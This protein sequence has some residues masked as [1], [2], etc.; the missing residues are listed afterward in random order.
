M[1]NTIS[2]KN[3]YSD[4]KSKM[5]IQDLIINF[6]NI[7]KDK[8]LEFVR[9]NTFIN[10]NID[11]NFTKNIQK[12]DFT[13]K[14]IVSLCAE[15]YDFLSKFSTEYINTDLSSNEDKKYIKPEFNKND[16]IATNDITEFNFDPI[17]IDSVVNHFIVNI[18]YPFNDKDITLNEFNSTFTEIIQKKDMI[19]I[20]KKCI[21][22]LPDY[23]KIRFINSFNSYFSDMSDNSI[24]SIKMTSFGKATYIYK[25]SKN[26]PVNDINSF[27]KIIAIPNIVSHF[28]KILSNRILSYL[29]LNN[30]LDFNIQKGCIPG[31]SNPLTQQ[32]MKV[33]TSINDAKSNNKPIAILFVDISDA[34][35]SIDRKALEFILNYYKIG[36]NCINY[37][38]NYYNNFSYY[39][40]NKNY[41]VGLVNWNSRGIIQ[42]CPLSPILF[43][44]VINFFLN[45]LNDKYLDKC[46][47]NIA[48]TYKFLFSA[49][50]DDI[51]IVV[52]NKDYL[53][54]IYTELSQLLASVGLFINKNKSGIMLSG[55]S[56]EDIQNYKLEDIPIITD[57][58]YLGANINISDSRKPVDEFI[59]QLYDRL[60]F[61]DNNN[62]DDNMKV[63]IFH[64][65]I[66]PWITR[67][68]ANLYDL[69]NDDKVNVMNV[70]SHFQR[71]WQ[72]NQVPD[73][74]INVNDV[75]NNSDDNVLSKLTFEQLYIDVSPSTITCN[76][77][78]KIKE[79]Y[80][81]TKIIIKK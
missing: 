69:T 15:I 41:D 23:H 39:I 19:G 5:T 40:K 72:D 26:G 56:I 4:I 81:S 59:T 18:K 3:E 20:S 75:L 32:I 49:Y 10:Y 63:K 57:Y 48:N 62:E 2:T 80:N 58:T 66:L 34:F 77:A 27:R 60:T 52:N 45:Y 29:K 51:C 28:H 22:Y 50:V 14:N 31:I 64:K 37:I 71:K 67:Q 12:Y 25:E 61:L 13:S 17:N 74:F 54:D 38:M 79:N 65:N 35:G 68:T 73:I 33:K 11:E 36:Q 1:G 53:Q 70:I 30:L 46:G 76:S 8:Y 9:D 43:I 47:Y 44:I 7:P 16:I 24:E 6:Y 55:Y 78:S 42:G 21:Q